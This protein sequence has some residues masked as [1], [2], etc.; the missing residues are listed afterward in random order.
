MQHLCMLSHM[1]SRDNKLNMML[2]CEQDAHALVTEQ[3]QSN[4][5]G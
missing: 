1:Q 5:G 2:D 3:A 4:A